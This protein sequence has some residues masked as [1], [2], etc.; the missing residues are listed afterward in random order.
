MST[1]TRTLRNMP[2]RT[3]LGSAL[4]LALLSPAAAAQTTALESPETQVP[5]PLAAS[6]T[7]STT[8]HAVRFDNGVSVWATE[9]PT[10]DAPM[11]NLQGEDRVAVESGRIQ[12]PVRL[13][14]YSNYAAFVDRY[15]ISVYRG[16]DIDLVRPLAT[17]PATGIG[18][19]VWDGA[20]SDD[21]GL[22]PDDE[23]QVLVRAYDQ[24][25]N[26]DESYP[27][28]IRL[29]T[30]AEYRQSI[31]RLRQDSSAEW[32]SLGSE[33]ALIAQ[34]NASNAYGTSNLRLQNIPLRGSRILLT[35][36]GVP[37]DATV[38]IN[39]DWAAVDRQRA[40]SASYL[41]PVGTHRFE[42]EQTTGGQAETRTLEINVTGRY[43]FLVAIADMT[44]S[45]SRVDGS[46]EALGPQDNYDATVYEGRLAF[47]LKGK[48][49]GKYLITAH[50]DTQERELKELFNGFTDADARDL[51]HRLDP[52]QYYPVYGDDS[53]TYRDVDTQGRLY[54]RVDWDKSRALLGNFQTDVAPSEYT[55]YERGMFGAMVDWNRMQTTELG[56]TKTQLKAFVSEAETSPGHS[57][58]LGTGGSLYYLRH[59]D[60]LPGSEQVVVE[61]RDRTTG[62]V[63]S[64]V[65]LV[66]GVDYEINDLQGRLLLTQPLSQIVRGATFGL[67]RDAPLTGY[68]QRLRVD[69]E[70]IPRGFDPEQTTAGFRGKHWLGEHLAVGGTY[71]NEQRGGEDYRLAGVDVTLQA[72]RGTYLR[73]ERSRSEATAAPA[74]YSDD[75]GLSFI[76]TGPTESGQSGNATQVDARINLQELGWTASEWT[77]SAWWRDID[78][79]YSVANTR[80]GEQI[81]EQGVSFLGELSP[82]WRL[83]GRYSLAERGTSALEQTQVELDA[84]LSPQHR[85]TNELRQVKE[86]QDGTSM[87]GILLATRYGYRPWAALELYGIGQ[88]TVD[89]DNGRYRDN[90]AL[91]LGGNYQFQNLSSLGAEFSGGDRGRAASVQTDYRINAD[92]SFYGR[93][94]SSSDRYI[95]PLF[96]GTYGP[97]PSGWTVGQRWRMSNRSNVFQE[98]QH[99]ANGNQSGLMNTVGWDFYPVLGWTYGATLQTGEIERPDGVIDRNAVSVSA[100]YSSPETDWSS[101]I[102]YR[103]DE[104]LE[105]RTQWV[106]TNVL[107]HKLSESLRLAA[108]MNYADTEDDLQPLLDTRFAE[109]NLG[110]AWRPVDSARWAMFGRY[111]YL[112][113]LAGGGEED[114]D[115]YDQRTRIASLEGVYMPTPRWELAAKLARREGQVRFGRQS[116]GAWFDSDATLTALQARAHLGESRWSGLTEYRRLNVSQGGSRDGWLMGVDRDVGK[117]LRLGAGYNFTD[118]SDNLT[119]QEYEYKGWF[120][121]IVGRY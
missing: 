101:K 53:V 36:Q 9:D 108:H 65:E 38:K 77:G 109:A 15:E 5:A 96:A 22:L 97:E 86:T 107:H 24:A 21:V 57:E 47:Y 85:L 3:L 16:T 39:G 27:R 44:I 68:E 76:E 7:P 48:V 100:S 81:H 34:A 33:E 51:F 19:L 84:R 79:G 30:P 20:L 90:N 105:Q 92:H 4:C 52:N 82:R 106:T 50:A 61:V 64:T 103:R 99:L 114:G 63:E 98:S 11:L 102:E 88:L 67:T 87:Q 46:V 37:V 89:D 120:L 32:R 75:G 91:T 69:Y 95:D 55:R 118:F 14:L 78:A 110:F 112:Y 18:E 2:R 42:I 59:T 41:V 71:A 25:G 8:A 1:T 66:R 45:G 93:L 73:V 29:V 83:A 119:R 56:E 28:R 72:G 62:Q 49:Q 111:T 80:L 60:V 17:L 35:G 94:T 10:L 26:F 6:A 23:V 31:D 58:F 116:G 104:G 13:H 40:L 70:Y 54:V 113:D 43:H 115:D 12:G 121:N 117:N 74:F